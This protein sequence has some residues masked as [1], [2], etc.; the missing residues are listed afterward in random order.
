[1]VKVKE[2]RA[3]KP[4]K[5]GVRCGMGCFACFRGGL[6]GAKSLHSRR[7]SMARGEWPCPLRSSRLDFVDREDYSPPRVTLSKESKS[8]KDT[9]GIILSLTIGCY[10]GCVL[11]LSFKKR[12]VEG[13][14]AG[15]LPHNL[16]E[17]LMWP[18]WILVIL[19]WNLL[20]WI[21]LRSHQRGLGIPDFVHAVPVLAGLRFFAGGCAIACFILTV[22]CWL[23]MGRSW[24][25]AII[26]A[27]TAPLVTTGIYAFVRH[28]IYSLSMILM[29]S[30]LI[31][32]PTFPMSAIALFH[33]IFLTI[34]VQSEEKYLRA[35]HGSIYV[36]YCKS[37][38]RFFPRLAQRRIFP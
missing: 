17:L 34:K 14:T 24:S 33:M 1:M 26:P 10:W 28:P 35:V 12:L 16:V 3:N 4:A 32:I 11:V 37:T 25:M 15:L 8:M 7:E 19:T 13:Q 18:F 38:G 21:A 20:P 30:S 31:V 5:L 6:A 27:Q 36:D 29:I 9:P 2:K 23:R 22:C